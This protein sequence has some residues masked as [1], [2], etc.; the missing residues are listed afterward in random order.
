MELSM[1][2]PYLTKGTIPETIRL[3]A[4]PTSVVFALDFTIVIPVSLL[5]A[6][7]LWRRRAYG[8]I[9]AMI[10]LV[11]GFTFG[12]VLCIGTAVLAF[13]DA[14]GKWDPL[15]PFYIVLAIGGLTGVSLLL[16][17]LEMN[18]PINIRHQVRH[19]QN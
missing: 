19:H 16:K 2:I 10:M 17:N 6:Y 8:Y 11:K 12:L 4:H 7:L 14:Y 9:L 13:S 1:I 5:A 3:T 18:K 15:M